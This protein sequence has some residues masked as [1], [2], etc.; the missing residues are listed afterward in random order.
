MR[1]VNRR[2]LSWLVILVVL[3]LGSY[4]T[5][6]LQTSYDA[7]VVARENAQFWQGIVEQTSEAVIVLDSTGVVRHFN[8]A[9]ER[10]FGVPREVALGKDIAWM[11]TPEKW[12]EH[13]R[14][15]IA[16]MA[17]GASD[18]TSVVLCYAIGANNHP[19]YVEIRTHIV[20]NHDQWYAVAQI[21]PAKDV[22]RQTLEPQG[23]PPPASAIP[24]LELRLDRS[25]PSPEAVAK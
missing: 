15:L 2:Q 1:T 12:T 4:Q 11:M 5:Y 7:T 9:A 3:L 23:A 25:S 17:R 19:I 24:S 10:I 13:Q 6:V 16:A 18:K 20:K 21:Q 8:P 22:R 14:A